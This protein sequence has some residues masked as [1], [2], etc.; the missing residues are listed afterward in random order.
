MGKIGTVGLGHW[1]NREERQA[2][3]GSRGRLAAFTLRMATLLGGDSSTATPSGRPRSV[4]TFVSTR[5]RSLLVVVDFSLLTLWHV[6]RHPWY[7]D[8]LSLCSF[9][10]PAR[11]GHTIRAFCR[12]LLSKCGSRAQCW[13]P[14]IQIYEGA[15]SESMVACRSRALRVKAPREPTTTRRDHVQRYSLQHVLCAPRSIIT[16]R[17]PGANVWNRRLQRAALAQVAAPTPIE[18]AAECGAGTCYFHAFHIPR[19]LRSELGSREKKEGC[20]CSCRFVI[21]RWVCWP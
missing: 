18:P 21:L 1:L 4:N 17:S 19:H 2:V 3:A 16:T 13:T 15:S 10:P 9:P 7:H 5:S 8:Q 6:K 11:E 20:R 12:Y 14:L